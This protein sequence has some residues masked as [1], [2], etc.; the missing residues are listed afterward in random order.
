MKKNIP[1]VIAAGVLVLILGLYMVTYQVRYTEVAVVTTFG[2]PSE[3]QVAEGFH[4]KWPWPIQRVIKYDGRLRILEGSES[5]LRTRDEQNLVVLGYAGWRIKDPG[6]FI[7]AVGQVATAETR[8]RTMLR[9]HKKT[10]VGKF[11][12]AE[13]VSKG[14]ET[15]LEE[16]ERL[17]YEPL[18]R[19]ALAQFGIEI[20]KGMVGIKRISLPKSTTQKVFDRMRADQDKKA[21]EFRT[22]G[23]AT[24]AG[25]R[26][27]AQ[28]ERTRIL[29][30]ADPLIWMM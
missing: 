8:L 28:S 26:A 18:A 19:D 15:K 27:R 2:K 21:N 1:T 13:I 11:T 3:S 5:E 25:I 12:L 16:I 6:R 4:F 30:F 17:M 14:Q 7:E 10:A 20:E 24:A 29:S 23:Q 22:S 9:T